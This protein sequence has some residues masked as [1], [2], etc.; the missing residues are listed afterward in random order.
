MSTN[1]R[2]RRNRKET[3]HLARR[4]SAKTSEG[5]T[6]ETFGTPSEFI[7]EQWPATGRAQA[8][9]YGE[10]LPYIRNVKIEG[11]YSIVV[12]D[13]QETVQYVFENGLTVCENDGMY[14]DAPT[15]GEPDYRVLSVK[16]YKPLRLEVMK[17]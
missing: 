11:N 14:L 13:E 12:S 4:I 3:L 7:G 1:R 6:Y 2:L 9:M 8:Q 15:N 16:P 5:S 17:R 10:K